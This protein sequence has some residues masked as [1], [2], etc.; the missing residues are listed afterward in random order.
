[1]GVPAPDASRFWGGT[2]KILLWWERLG[3]G[4]R[5]AHQACLGAIP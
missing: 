5:F 1:M 4:V 2:P 3:T